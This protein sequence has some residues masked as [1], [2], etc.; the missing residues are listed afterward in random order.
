MRSD[1]EQPYQLCD[2]ARIGRY[3]RNCSKVLFRVTADHEV[4]FVSNDRDL[5][6]CYR[7]FKTEAHVHWYRAF[8]K[9][10]LDATMIHIRVL[11]LLV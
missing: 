8:S 10:G 7:F 5:L 3:S 2:D 4:E 11:V 6:C 9:R 1:Q